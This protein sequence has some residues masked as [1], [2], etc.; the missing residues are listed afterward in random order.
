[1]KMNKITALILCACLLGGCADGADTPYSLA[2]VQ[3]ET[4]YSTDDFCRLFETDSDFSKNNSGKIFAVLGR[5]KSDDDVTD[6]DISFTSS[7]KSSKLNANYTISCRFSGSVPIMLKKDD[8]AIICGSLFSVSTSVIILQN[9]EIISFD[10]TEQSLDKNLPADLAGNEMISSSSSLASSSSEPETS[11]S[12]KPSE[13]YSAPKNSE[14]TSSSSK[15]KSSS[16]AESSEIPSK[17]VPE[18]T[19]SDKQNTFQYV[20]NTSTK[21]FHLPTCSSVK[22]IKPENY[23]TIDSR[24]S[25]IAQGYSPCKNCNP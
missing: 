2:Q 1:M 13:D 18:V 23:A 12:S 7:F 3:N 24:E 22:K 20:L 21:K 14:K 17:S 11:S 4:V 6:S 8:V 25:A 15:P 16:K 9:C 19:S 5:I 10:S